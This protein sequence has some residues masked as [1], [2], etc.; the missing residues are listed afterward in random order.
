MVKRAELWSFLMELHLLPIKCYKLT[1]SG[2]IV[3]VTYRRQAW[4]LLFYFSLSS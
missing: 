1:I 2:A 3:L 4:A